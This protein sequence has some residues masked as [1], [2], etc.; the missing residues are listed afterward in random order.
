[1]EV[2]QAKEVQVKLAALVRT[3]VNPFRP[4]LVAGVDVSGE[5]GEGYLHAAVVVTEV[6]SMKVKQIAHSISRPVFPYVPGL[7]SFREIP[8][9][10]EAFKSVCEPP[11]ILMVDG[12]GLAH[13]RRFGLACHLGVLLGL[14]SIGCAKSRLI[15]SYD[16]PGEDKGAWSP[17]V[18]RDEIIGAA[19]RTKKGVRP[20]FISAGNLIN[21]PD[22][23]NWVIQCGRGYRIP[24]PTRI[25][26][27]AV[28]SR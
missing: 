10:T 19:L 28:S 3:R 5:D 9:L 20:I 12:Q 2:Q 11:D 4:G 17:L 1:M 15:G 23:L 22:A 25:A 16:M 26:H 27:L 13:P 21:L 7:L 8:A 18:D 14:P 24:E 6:P